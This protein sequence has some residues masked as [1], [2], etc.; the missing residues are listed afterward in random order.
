VAAA[1]QIVLA[2]ASPRRAEILR[3]MRIAFRVDPPAVDESPRPDEA[4]DALAQ[5]LAVVKARDV[6]VRAGAVLPV[7]A[8]DT[9]VALDGHALGKPIDAGHG[10]A[11]LQMLS[12]RTHDVLTAVAVAV[13]GRVECRVS[14]SRVTFRTLDLD[15]ARA[16]W[17]TGEGADK[18]GGY[19]I[20]G[21]GGILVDHIEGSYSGIVGLPVALT[22]VLLRAFGVDTWRDRAP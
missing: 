11:M 7:L 8:A 18:A 5:R 22:E 21:V 1:P 13:P 16:Y 6:L 14:R 12:G 9:V 10:V 20:Q 3:Q 15:E 17:T 2:S 4:P 19:G